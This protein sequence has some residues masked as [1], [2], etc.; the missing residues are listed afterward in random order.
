MEE[1]LNWLICFSVCV[2]VSSVAV[3]GY[4]K[5]AHMYEHYNVYDFNYCLS[6]SRVHE[7]ACLSL[8]RRSRLILVIPMC[9]RVA[10]VVV[11]SDGGWM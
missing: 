10:R 8:R 1:Y 11:A 4:T 5:E 6:P 3:A 2:C 7:Y 9:V